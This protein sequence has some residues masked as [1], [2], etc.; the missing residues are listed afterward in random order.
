[1]DLVNQVCG[2]FLDKFVIV[3]IDDILIYSRS[4]E[5]H[6]Q[7][8]HLI[9]EL[10]RKERLYAKFSKCEFWIRKVDLLGHAVSQEGIHVDPS[11][12]KTM[13]NWEIPRISTEIRQLLDLADFY[14]R[15]IKNFSKIAKPLTTLTQKGV[16]FDWEYQQEVAFQTLK[17]MLYNASIL[18]L[19]KGMEDFIVYSDA[20]KEDFG[21]III[22]RVK[23]IAYISRQ[24]KSHEVNYTTLDLEL[25]AVVFTLKVW[26][27]IRWKS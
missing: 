6:G 25:G 13:E 21:C 17:Q 12:I 26:R 8:L 24:L 2:P 23:V 22:Q 10:L 3:F 4:E 15:F 14:R 19:P 9:L 18:S 27:Q 7:R 5:E 20:L 1:M 16:R 11:K